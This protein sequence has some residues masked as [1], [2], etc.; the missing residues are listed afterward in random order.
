[1]LGGLRGGSARRHS[2]GLV[3]VALVVVARVRSSALSV[4][5][6]RRRRAW[7]RVRLTVYI[8]TAGWRCIAKHALGPPQ[9]PPDG[10][11]GDSG[12]SAAMDAQPERRLVGE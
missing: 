5:R 4:R 9:V 1:M 10:V 8:S 12:W 6:P 3:G 2:P 11:A 7:R